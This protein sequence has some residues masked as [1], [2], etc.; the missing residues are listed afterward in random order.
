[1]RDYPHI[2]ESNICIAKK[3]IAKFEKSNNIYDNL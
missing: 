1:M 2:H 3:Q